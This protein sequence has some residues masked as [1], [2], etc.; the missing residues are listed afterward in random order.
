[1]IF[2][3]S[4][5]RARPVGGCRPWRK[6]R[7]A[8]LGLSSPSGLSDNGPRRISAANGRG[9]MV[10]DS[11]GQGRQPNGGDPPGLG[12][13]RSGF[14]QAPWSRGPGVAV[15]DGADPARVWDYDALRDR[16]GA[17][18]ATLAAQGLSAGQLVAVPERP[19]LDLVLMQHAL[20]RSA[21]A[22]LP[23]GDGLAPESLETLLAA[24]GAEWIWRTERP[25]GGRLVATHHR[26]ARPSHGR[27]MAIASGLGGR[28]QRQQWGPPGRDAQQRQPARLGRPGEPP[29]RSRRRGP[30]AVL[31]AP[32][33]YRRFGDSRI[34]VPW[35]VP[36]WSCAWASSPRRW[37]KTWD[38]TPSPTSPWSP[39]CWPD[40]STWVALLPR[41][42]GSVLVGGQSL[43]TS[44]A[45][46]ALAAGW[47]LYVSYGMT[48]TASQVACSDRL[49]GTHRPRGRRQAPAGS[50]DRLP[51]LSRFARGPAG[52]GTHGHGGLR[53]PGAGSRV[54]G[55]RTAGSGPR[56]WP[57]WT[58][59]GCSRCLGRADDVLVT[60]GVKV[61]PAKV[62]A[63]LAEAPGVRE[64][65]VVG[66]PDPVWGQ[67]LVALYTGAA[68]PA[69]LDAWCRGQ[70]P[71]AE[72]PR[73]F[74]QCPTLP[75]LPSGKLDRHRL[76]ELAV[77][78]GAESGL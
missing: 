7:S 69:E 8:T 62:E 51:D 73:T 71:G 26:T 1:M 11:L 35:L 50:G 61:H 13:G 3:Q 63:D 44:L 64:V 2:R 21:V 72:R 24:T 74:I 52:T 23:I 6:G 25:D 49:T 20:A 27:P 56:T 33:A 40:C 28:D 22:L 31:L 68:S 66:V 60:A 75:S 55:W 70:L 57:A 76:Q 39:P 77:A 18:A 46:R 37:P 14:V 58:R 47:P 12:S 65:A 53:Q 42:C 9:R 59:P 30:V 45:A 32:A 54:K 48:E 38:A 67:R 36:R 4:P 29:T 43:S 19:A 15:I 34:A 5:K 78:Q 17:R 10:V 16:A 41:A